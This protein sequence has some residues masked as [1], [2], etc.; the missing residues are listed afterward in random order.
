MRGARL[1]VAALVAI[2]VLVALIPLGRWERSRRADEQVRGMQSVLAAVGRL[3]SPS[4]AAFRQLGSFDCLLYRRA[5]NPFALEVCVNDRGRVVEAIDRRG[6]AAR[7]WSLRD[8][9]SRSS[10][11]VDRARV[12]RLLRK[13]GAPR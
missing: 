7:I 6:K 5:R 11:L 1:A 8:D 9:P 3:D 13:M 4:L 12:E 10:V 2:A